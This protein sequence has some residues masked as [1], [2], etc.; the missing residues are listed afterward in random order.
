MDRDHPLGTKLKKGQLV[1]K[2]VDQ[3]KEKSHGHVGVNAE[4]YLGTGKQLKYGK[5]GRGPDY[6]HGSP[7]IREQLEEALL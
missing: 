3:G 2:T 7:T 4:F 1:G 5:T 6:T